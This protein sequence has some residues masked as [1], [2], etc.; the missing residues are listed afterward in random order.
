MAGIITLHCETIAEDKSYEEECRIAKIMIVFSKALGSKKI[1]KS[2]ALFTAISAVHYCA[3]MNA[4]MGVV[5]DNKYFRTTEQFQT[6]AKA[7]ERD[8]RTRKAV[9]RTLGMLDLKATEKQFSIPE[10]GYKVVVTR[11]NKVKSHPK[12]T[13]GKPSKPSRTSKASQ[14]VA[15][16][17]L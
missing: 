7:V 15:I 11:I 17:V 13:K 8:A 5:T 3:K 2:S 4:G 12:K 16:A 14:T 6:L 1:E 10:W 9:S